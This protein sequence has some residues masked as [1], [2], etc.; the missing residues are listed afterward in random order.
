MGRLGCSC[1]GRLGGRV[2]VVLM[3][4]GWGGG[5]LGLGCL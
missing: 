5:G 2:K 4:L 1:P 3:L